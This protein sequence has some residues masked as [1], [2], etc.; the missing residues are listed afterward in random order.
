MYPEDDLRR[1]FWQF[2]RLRAAD[3]RISDIF[4][5][6]FI[7]LNE[8]EDDRTS[9]LLAMY[10][11]VR[12]P[13]TQIPEETRHGSGDGPVTYLTLQDALLAFL[14][15][16]VATN[17]GFPYS[18][19]TWLRTVVLVVTQAHREPRLLTVQV[20]LNREG[21]PTLP[22]WNPEASSREFT[23]TLDGSW[24]CLSKDAFDAIRNN[25]KYCF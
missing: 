25:L 5:E 3:K 21:S 9:A 7:M 17:K 1:E 16:R 10:S 2:V 24:D 20:E 18:Y 14:I 6:A 22:T 11:D 23:L 4:P 15:Y 19:E 13:G 12:H 8:I